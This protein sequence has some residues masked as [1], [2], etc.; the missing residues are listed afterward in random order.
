MRGYAPRRENFCAAKRAAGI[1]PEK[2]V[3]EVRRRKDARFRVRA[4]KCP[5]GFPVG[6]RQLVKKPRSL[7]PVTRRKKVPSFSSATCASKKILLRLQ[8]WNV[9]ADFKL[10]RCFTVA[11]LFLLHGF[12][13]HL[14]EFRRV[15]FI[16]HALWH[17]KTPHFLVLSILPCL[18][19]KWGAV[20]PVRRA[21]A[22]YTTAPRAWP[23]GRC[24]SVPFQLTTFQ[25]PFSFARTKTTA[26]KYHTNGAL[27]IRNM[28]K[29][30][31]SSY[32]EMFLLT[33]W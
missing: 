12:H 21:L 25:S 7:S 16:W 29:R 19:N 14:F 23:S 22:Y 4:K 3:G 5:A 18:S 1:A 30:S 24:L 8:A 20:Q 28:R 33:S 31:I 15:S 10:P 27:S 13:D 26:I 2:R 11:Q 9:I 32:N 6:L 17:G